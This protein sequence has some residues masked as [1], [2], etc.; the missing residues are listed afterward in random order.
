MYNSIF[1]FS[2]NLIYLEV[3]AYFEK[4]VT[5]PNIPA[6][7][8]INSLGMETGSLSM[9][10]SNGTTRRVKFFHVS[11]IPSSKEGR[12]ALHTRWS[13]PHCDLLPLHPLSSSVWGRKDQSFQH[14]CSEQIKAISIS[15][16]KSLF[17]LCPFLAD[18]QTHLSNEKERLGSPQGFFN[19]LSN[20][21]LQKEKLILWHYVFMKQCTP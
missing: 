17:H 15:Q 4:F 9:V 3:L 5:N 20:S 8:M 10:F 14:C 19:Q 6:I 12:N 13:V 21:I 1:H 18:A 16:N 2:L 7:K 11:A